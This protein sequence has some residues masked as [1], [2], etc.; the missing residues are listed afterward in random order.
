MPPK[1]EKKLTK[2]QEARLAKKAEKDADKAKKEN[3]LSNDGLAQG[4]SKV[5][6]TAVITGNLASQP[7]SRDLKISE[8]SITTYGRN[9]VQDTTLELN[10][11]RRYGLIGQNGS[12]KSTLLA[13]IAAKENLPIPDIIDMWFLDSEAAPSEMTALEA[14]IDKVK[15]EHER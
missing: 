8:F 10:F 13:A 14:V 11:G 2:A 15:R 6:E 12:G 9:L 3:A 5:L 1:K 7:N 4:R